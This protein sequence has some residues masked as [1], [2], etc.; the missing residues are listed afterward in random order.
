VWVGSSGLVSSSSYCTPE[1]ANKCSYLFKYPYKNR[2]VLLGFSCPENYVWD[3]VVNNTWRFFYCLT[4]HD[5]S[6]RRKPASIATDSENY[7]V[8]ASDRTNAM[9]PNTDECRVEYFLC[10]CV[11]KWRLYKELDYEIRNGC[12]R[13]TSGLEWGPLVKF[14]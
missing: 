13:N 4:Q 9:Y 8:P 5:I 3:R 12:F 11:L 10:V 14:L 2:M 6:T 7:G 1:V